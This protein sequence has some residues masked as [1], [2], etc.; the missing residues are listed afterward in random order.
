MTHLMEIWSVWHGTY[1]LSGVVKAATAVAS[2]LTLIMLIRLLPRALGLP[3]PEDLRRTNLALEREIAERERAETALAAERD[4]FERR[5]KEH[6]E[7]LL[8]VKDELADDQEALARLHEFGTRMPAT[9]EL[10]P[11]LEEVLAALRRPAKRRLWDHS[12]LQP[13]IPSIG[14]RGPA[15]ISGRL[16]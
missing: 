5:V 11:L 7:A 13:E 16:P 1:R 9:T 15:R 4:N 14:N 3:A 10:Q 2:M 8:A 12:T 6:A